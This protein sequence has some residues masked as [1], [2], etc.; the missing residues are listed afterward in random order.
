MHY[1][2][3]QLDTARAVLEGNLVAVGDKKTGTVIKRGELTIMSGDCVFIP[4]NPV[5]EEKIYHYNVRG[6]KTIWQL[7]FSWKEQSTVYLYELGGK[8]RRFIESLTVRGGLVEI[9][10][11]P[12]KGYVLY[13]Q[14]M[15]QLPEMLW[16]EGGLV[17]DTGFDS[18]SFENW[19]VQGDSA[20]LAVK[21][22]DY[23]QAYLEIKGKEP[24]GVSQ[25][26]NGLTPGKEYIA[27]VWV[28]VI[29]EKNAILVV[30]SGKELN[31]QVPISESKVKII[32]IIRIDLGQPGND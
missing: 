30:Q 16:S 13:K 4:W 32:R 1:P 29:G 12:D 6:G 28:N 18:R 9:E 11:Q 3:L 19:K 8:G 27:S 2:V 20:L 5:T 24:A 15:K 14:E 23:G 7:P 26:I 22:T 25:I 10:A 17:K 21:E 31:E